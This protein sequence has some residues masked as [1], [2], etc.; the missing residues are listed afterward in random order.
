ESDHDGEQ[1]LKP[2][3]DLEAG[4][5][6]ELLITTYPNPSDGIVNLSLEGS[7]S[8]FSYELHNLVG[9]LVLQ[10]MNISGE[11]T[12]IDLS[13]LPKGIYTLTVHSGTQQATDKVIVQ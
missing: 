4:F 13:E 10:Q 3:T 1:N 5:E 8:G 11:S 6:R 9:Q 12:R 7:V 2:S